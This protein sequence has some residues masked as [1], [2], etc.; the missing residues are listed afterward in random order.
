MSKKLV[1]LISCV[2]VFALSGSISLAQENQI[3][4]GEFDDGLNAWGSYGSAGFNMEVVQSGALSGNNSVL[5][6]ITDASSA[7]S[8]GISQGGFQ[9]VQ[10]QTYPFG[11]I[12][13]SDQEREMVVLIQLSK[14]EVPSWTDI[15]LTRIQL[16]PDPQEYVLEY[17]HADENTIE[18]PG[19]SVNMYLMLKGQWWGM[20]GSDLNTKVWIDWVYFGAKPE[21]QDRSR[22]VNPT[23]D[24]GAIYEDTWVN[25][26]WMP[27]D[28]ALSHDVYMGEN[29]DDVNDGAEGTFVGNQ[30]ASSLVIGFPGFP[31]PDGL[32]PGTTYYWRIDEVNDADPNSPWKGPVWSFT[33]PPKIAYNPSPPDG[34]KFV[35]PDVVFNWGTGFGSKLHTIYFGDNFDDV[36]NAVVGL[37]QADTTYTPGTLELE[38]T[39][40]WRV[41]EFSGS[42]TD[43]GD[44]W[45][46]TV[47]R[48]GGGLKAE[49]FNNRDLSGQPVLTRVDPGVDFSWGN[50]DVPGEN[51]PDPSI[52]VND[53]SARWSGELEVDITDTYTF[54][55]TANNGYRLWLDGELI[56]DFWD[57]P[58]TDTLESEPIELVG[59]ELYSIQMEYFEGADTATAQLF[60]ESIKRPR[61]IIPSGALQLPLKAS[62]PKPSNHAVDVSQ[63]QA[64]S[65]SAV[66]DA[67]SH[68]VYFG[69]DEETVKNAD[70]S[71][72]DYKGS[73]NLGSES[74]DPGL[75]QWNTTY[76]WR[77][78]EVKADGSVQM[79]SLWSFATANFIVVDDMESYNDLDEAEPDSNRIYIAWVDGFDNPTINGSI[80]GYSNPP[81]AEQAIVNSGSQSM[82][83]V[84]DNAV[85]KSE[86]TLTLSS[87][88]DWTVNG[89]NTL[90]VWFRG[91]AANAAE[92][93]YVALNGTAVVNHDNPDAATIDEWTRWDID[94]QKFG[95]NLAN[96]NSLTLG[97]GNRNNPVAGGAGMMYFDDIRLYVIQL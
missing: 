82:P 57:N 85:G 24:D 58:T 75:L 26:R 28:Y 93:L 35:D 66:A 13:K 48:A 78:D 76:Y 7:A 6:D 40:Y 50:A 12:A 30:P 11:F 92:T 51:S 1:C 70:T 97:L 9:L 16:T 84:F 72:P 15:F 56:I 8:I 19:W 42:S 89:I 69:T 4:N 2:L 64:M 80:V 83:F 25:L 60:W 54:S 34:A 39:Y 32:V 44:V 22:A 38:K 73:R 10:G 87:N 27:G 61:Q 37:P 29:F 41:D 55:I 23:P 14:P 17:T 36:N 31:Y 3:A 88:R 43:K 81:F 45:S 59:G 71:S 94:L 62:A 20:A 95:V 53:F 33:V 79:G 67:A 18:H 90:T 86:A 74:Y 5:I 46:F 68:Q 77:V 91:E 52:N 21:V 47:T 96:V 63:T 65:W 49:Y